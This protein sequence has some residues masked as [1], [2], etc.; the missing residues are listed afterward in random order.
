MRLIATS[1]AILLA[2]CAS[3]AP[4]EWSVVEPGCYKKG[5]AYAFL[6]SDDMGLTDIR[7]G[8]LPDTGQGPGLMVHFRHHLDAAF[9]ESTRQPDLVIAVGVW[10]S[11]C[12]AIVEQSACPQAN[13]IYSA[14]A[15][16]SI[17]VGHA[18][19][20]PSGIT[21]LHGTEYF[22]S[23]RDGEGNQLNWSYYGRGHPL[24]QTISTALDKL[25]VCAKPATDALQQAGL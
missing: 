16:A 20:S 18:F 17:P 24:Q 23:S 3:T 6:A 7:I 21:V 11:S 10:Q 9:G 2:G 8:R 25:S 14:L 13:A 12:V 22:L 5:V 4:F 1:L 15:S 19:D